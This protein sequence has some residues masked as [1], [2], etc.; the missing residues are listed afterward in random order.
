MKELD[1]KVVGLTFVEHYPQ[2]LLDIE[3]LLT[4][5]QKAAL[6]W[7]DDHVGATQIDVLLIRAPQNEHDANAVEVHVPSLG[8]RRSMIGHVPRDLAERL[9]PSLDRGDRWSARI[10]AVLVTPEHPDRPGVEVTIERQT[11]A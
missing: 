11:V 1:F 10:G 7:S 6:G 2:N 5:S 3:G 8:R 4:E 9:A